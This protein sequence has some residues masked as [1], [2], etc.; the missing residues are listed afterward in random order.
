MYKILFIVLIVCVAIA[1]KKSDSQQQLPAGTPGLM[2]LK[3]GNAWYYKKTM[4]DSA[5]GSVTGTSSDTIA[6]P[7]GTEVNNVVYFQVTWSSMPVDYYSFMDNADSNTVQKIDSITRYTFFKRVS[8]DG[9]VDAWGDTV[10]TRCPGQ[11]QLV[12]YAGASTVNSYTGC[13]Q[14]V[15]LVNDCTGE[16]FEKWVYY[17]KPN[18]GI[19]RIEHYKVKNDR[20]SFYLDVEEDLQSFHLE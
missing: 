6:I 19:V 12:G 17:L 5:T 14:N 7:A 16:T 9:P 4:H 8:A 18:T 20:V 2:P 11:N 10:T 3:V 15:V 1:C 13:L